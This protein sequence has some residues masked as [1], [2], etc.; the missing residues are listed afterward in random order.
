MEGMWT[1][2]RRYKLLFNDFNTEEHASVLKRK[3]KV[4]LSGELALEDAVDLS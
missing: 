3:I 1:P 2:G 4:A